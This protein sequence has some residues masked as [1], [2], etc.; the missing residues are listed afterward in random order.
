MGVVIRGWFFNKNF[1]YAKNEMIYVT[2]LWKQSWI[3]YNP[4]FIL[5]RKKSGWIHHDFPPFEPWL[6]NVWF[7]NNQGVVLYFKNKKHDNSQ[8]MVEAMHDIILSFTIVVVQGVI[9]F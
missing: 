5:D 2:S 7:R 1:M 6:P 8:K 3:C 9:C 4:L